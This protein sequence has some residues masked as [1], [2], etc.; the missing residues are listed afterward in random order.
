MLAG[1]TFFAL[2]GAGAASADNTGC[3][4]SGS[5]ADC[6]EVPSD[7]VRYTTDVKTIN[8]TGDSGG[9]TT[10]E[11]GVEG[12]YLTESG[13]SGSTSTT[14]NY[15]LS[16]K[17]HLNLVPDEDNTPDTWVLANSA[18]QPIL[19]GGNYIVVVGD[20]TYSI[21]SVVYPSADALTKHLTASN[22]SGGTVSGSLTINNPKPFPGPVG[23][24][25]T[26]N[27]DGILIRSTGGNGG[28]GG[29]STVL[30][31]TWCSNGKTGG[32]AGSVVVNSNGAIT[33][34]GSSEK[35]YGISAVSQGGNGGDGGGSFGLFAS[36]A[37]AGGVGGAG[38]AVEVFL[39]Q[40]SS[41]ITHGKYGHGV[42]AVSRGGK[43]GGGGTPY[44]A[45]AGGD[46]GGRGGNA[47]SVVVE[48]HGSILTTGE[49]AYGINA[50]SVGGLAGDGSD[51]FG[52]GADGG[53]GGGSSQG[54]PV[55]VT[56][57]G[58]V[59]TQNSNSIGIFVQSVG[60]GG[61]DGGSTGGVF[62]VGG[63]GAS[64]GPGGTVKVYNS[65]TVKTGGA[66]GGTGDDAVGVFL[67][68]VGG[69]GGNGGGAVAVGA[70]VSLAIGGNG[71]I[72]GAGG[73]VTYNPLDG[74]AD[75]NGLQS[76]TIET[77][78]NRS[79]GIQAQSVGGGG[80]NGGYAYSGTA[81]VGG[82]SASISL[83]GKGGPGGASDAVIVNEK[84]VIT[85]A[86]DQSIG[87]FAQSV[88]GGGG[89]G[90]GSVA[91]AA[92]GGYNLSLAIGGK[93][94]SGG[95]SSTVNVDSVGVIDTKGKLSH[96]IMAQSVGGGGGNGG[97]SVAASLG[98]FSGSVALGGAAGV[99][100][101]GSDVTVTT[102]AGDVADAGIRTAGE[103]AIGILAQSVGGGGGNGGVAG[104]VSVG[105]GALGV[106]LGGAGAGGAVGGT[107]TVT[108]R[109]IIAT[110]G[111]T[112]SG[113]FAQSVGGGGGNG[114]AALSGTGGVVG[115]SVA[116]GGSGG[117]GSD[118]GVVT[119]SNYGSI[120]TGYQTI[121]LVDDEP[122]VELFGSRSYGIFAQSVGGGGGN[123]GFAIAGAV[124]VAIPDV[125]AG[126]FAISVGGAGGSAS[127]GK[128]VTVNNHGSVETFG[129]GSHAIFA[130]SVGGGGGNGGFAGAV[131][132]TVGNGASVGVGVG[133]SGSGG[134][135]A[136]VVTVNTFDASKKI[137]THADGADGIHA[138]SV[139]GGGGDGGFAMSGAFGFGGETSVNVAVA[140]G[141]AGGAG[142]TGGKVNVTTRQEITTYGQNAI[143]VMAQS[144]GGGGGNGGMAVTGTLAFSETAGA[145]GVSVGGAG[146]TGSISDKV[147]VDNYGAITTW[148]LDSMGILA[149]SI[150]GSGGNGGLA[151]AAQM[152]GSSKNAATVGVTIGGGAGDGNFGGEVDV[153]NYALGT[154][155]TNGLGAHGIKA[156]SIGG[157]G[158][159]GG[160]AV[161]AQ[162]G[163]SSGSE[164]QAS[165][166]LNVGASVGGDGGTGGYG[167]TVH[168]T[169]DGSIT[170][171]GPAAT[172][173]FA[174]SVGGGGGDGGGAVSAVGM[175]TDSTNASSRS[176]V[177]TVAIGGDGGSGN[178]GG[179]V[180]VDNNGSILTEGVSGHGVYAQSIGGGGGV[181]G[182]ANTLQVVVTKPVPVEG[183]DDITNKNNIQLGVTI[184]GG[185]GTGG[186]GGNVVVNNQGTIETRNEL[187]DG[188]YAQSVGAGG[189]DGGN[190]ALGPEG[191][192]PLPGGTTVI[193][194]AL[195]VF[196]LQGSVKKY[197]NLQVVVGGSGGA[198]GDGGTV[199]VNNDKNIT[200]HGSNSN[201]IFAQSVG[202][203]GGVGGKSTI[204]LTGLLGLG[205]EGTGGGDAKLVKVNQ[206]GG[207]TIETFGV[208][209]YGIFAQSV[210]G[211]GGVAGNVD[212]LFANKTDVGPFDLPA[213]NVGIGLA[214]GRDAGGGGDGGPVDVDVDGII[215]THG[216][217]AAGIFAQSVGG[218]GGMMGE[219]GND[220]PG[221][222][223]L[224][225][226][227]GSKGDVGNAGQVDV[228][229]TGTIV[230]AGNSATGIFAQSAAGATGGGHA[231]TAG[232]VNVTVNGSV[233]T[234][235]VLVEADDGTAE[236]PLRG[237]GATAIFAQSAADNNANNGNVVIAINGADAV[238]IGGRSS[239]INADDGYVG[240]GVWIMDGKTNTV[241][242]HGLITTVDGVDGGYAILAKGSDATHT[243]GDEA[244]SNFGTVTGSFNLGAGSNSFTN[245]IDAVFNSGRFANVGTGRTLANAGWI[246][247]GGARRVM[248]TDVTGIFSQAASATYGV[249][250]DMALTILL[251][252]LPLAPAEADVMI[253]SEA[254][255]FD[256]LV[257]LTLLNV[258]NVL[259]GEHKALLARSAISLDATALQ[260]LAPAS[261]VANYALDKSVATDLALDYAIDFS[262]E[263]LTQNQSALGE[264]INQVQL[265]GG[266][267]PLEPVIEALFNL[268]D[269]EAYSGALNQLTPESYAVNQIS[270]VTGS[271]QFENTLMSCRVHGG[272]DRFTAEGE[273]AW[274]SAFG[275]EAVR[276]TTAGNFGY[277]SSWGGL[278]MGAQVAV[279]DVIKAG[280]GVSY[281]RSS[282]D[283]GDNANGSG[284]HWQAGGVVKAVMGATTLAGTLTGG[285][286]SYDMGRLV[287]LPNGPSYL[288]RGDQRIDYIAAH[289]RLSHA[290]ANDSG[291]IRPY[292]DVGVT[293]VRARAFSETG[294]PVALDIVGGSDT[295]VTIEGAMEFGAEFQASETTVV[296]PFASIGMLAFPAGTSPGVSATFSEAPSAAAPFRSEA[297]MDKVFAE[298]RLGFDVVSEGGMTLRAMG[299]VQVG[300][301]SHSYGGNLKIGVPF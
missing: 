107:V 236:A 39:G 173:I 29:C 15:D 102:S 226:Q 48:N 264:Y 177:A 64:G 130:Q 212:R 276:E 222:S 42:Y 270:S 7:G 171:K 103:G 136:G 143:G 65:G 267:V 217:S 94:G 142:G 149:H 144:V 108:N 183:A 147:T 237:L 247:P 170:I 205:G 2:A 27:A 9:T 201:G 57:S 198:T 152:T 164:A 282:F 297:E 203:G 73:T 96:G 221:L 141:G 11:S 207:A 22:T 218:G 299:E 186:H 224:S 250:M 74:L 246:S 155:L 140:I 12:I 179:A 284:I 104:T 273:C 122:V 168:V 209:S 176:V 220:V 288:L 10:V 70:G 111:N 178:Y 249:D 5:V 239:R 121:T 294:G 93:G 83:G 289:A 234:G 58:S 135:N 230:T 4:V 41:I 266:S 36:D 72:G 28:N 215:R 253:G 244:V 158:G 16:K 125:P 86:G 189:G 229:L 257:D 292:V 150:G 116:V 78:G 115:I 123:G 62:S 131:A 274:A 223:L 204:G 84:G 278:S 174:Q 69:G 184:G 193:E 154:I 219:L 175:L 35:Q 187:S 182:R 210:G 254:M 34:N 87:L 105:S 280:L 120:T 283:I 101:V 159:N 195:G 97:F 255:S 256:G 32:S 106:S 285:T 272:A 180:T 161:T 301:T 192:F 88:G 13:G 71:A 43:G 262:P 46:E 240:V 67:Q 259:P 117:A 31:Y 82:I 49:A 17:V 129:L 6:P 258:G 127:D 260:L 80:G 110:R 55:T 181:G 89:N 3:G 196:G 25:V 167:N 281:A 252:V 68:S 211:G 275:G 269:L 163:K 242:N 132:M 277:D 225:W 134:G 54:S 216:N 1:A 52:I 21:N 157:G 85:T 232:N 296:R 291:Y 40:D 145:V 119:V 113:I 44:G 19:S 248:T 61:G 233:L 200:T 290:I 165:K 18:D 298:A 126:A 300:E 268:P 199:E 77:T 118:G 38:G 190:G 166:T 90:G 76:A 50:S 197:K 14:P 271:V 51:A 137:T 172:G 185:G 238:V 286:S 99:G 60:G 33:V 251:P 139:G 47:G 227:L 30:V 45:Y 66:I 295:F 169:N 95:A 148:G 241:T 231:G 53:Q 293:N 26:T 265:A 191:L 100:G 194:K 37:G 214:F 162:L 261:A 245:E 279:N 213:L 81:P 206:Y 112:A 146:G 202:G 20:G 243:G 188:I 124:G 138:Q 208:S 160:M 133:G 24:I 114:G 109:N 91:V 79:H 153:T 63:N 263:G 92:G 56:N 235:Q 287:E 128:Q 151:I 228:D 23:G 8:I 75:A 156:Q 59:E 98:G